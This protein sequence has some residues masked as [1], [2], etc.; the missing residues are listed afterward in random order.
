VKVVEP[1]IPVRKTEESLGKEEIKVALVIG[2]TGVIGSSACTKL[3]AA[4][5]HFTLHYNTNEGKLG[6]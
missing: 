1:E 2:A 6:S 4:G 3:S 5:F